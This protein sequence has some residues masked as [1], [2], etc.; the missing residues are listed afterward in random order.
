MYTYLTEM[1][2]FLRENSLLISALKSSITLF[3]PDPAHDNTRPY[4]KIADS[5][6]PLVR[7]LKILGVY[8]DTFFSFNNH[9]VQKANRVSKRNNV[10]KVLAG[11][12]WGQQNETLLMTYKALGRSSVN[13]A[14]PVWSTNASESNIGKIQRALNEA[15]SQAHIRCQVLTTYTVRLRCYRSRT[16]WTWTC[17]ITGTVSG[18]RERFSSHHHDVSSTKGNEGDNLHQTIKPCYYC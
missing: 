8:L 13:Y 14:A 4:F 16:S 1:S 17:S 9:C 2:Q 10:L 12:N 7:S 11:T 6:L 18:Y 15:S 3:T 5:E